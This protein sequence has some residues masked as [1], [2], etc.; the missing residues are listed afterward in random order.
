MSLSPGVMPLAQAAKMLGSPPEPHVQTFL[1]LPL[2]IL[3]WAPGG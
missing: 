3:P 1:H 2:Y